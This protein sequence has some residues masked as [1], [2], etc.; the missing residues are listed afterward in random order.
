M[1]TGE[2]EDDCGIRSVHG[3]IVNEGFA[4]FFE[5]HPV[6]P[7]SFVNATVYQGEV[8]LPQNLQESP[9]YYLAVM[10]AEDTNGSVEHAFAGE[11]EVA[12]AARVR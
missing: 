8:P 1:V 12:A 7:G 6:G 2:V 3:E 9:V 4:S 11:A 10:E 5:M